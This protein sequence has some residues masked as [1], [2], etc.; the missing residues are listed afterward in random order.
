MSNITFNNYFSQTITT[1]SVCT[2]IVISGDVEF[3]ADGSEELILDIK[4]PCNY[5]SNNDKSQFYSCNDTINNSILEKAYCY[6]NPFID[7]VNL[8]FEINSDKVL[9]VE[10]LDILGK[11]FFKNTENFDSGSH[12]LSFSTHEL[13]PATYIIRIFNADSLKTFKIVKQ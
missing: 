10:I 13:P 3:I 8:Y 5:E 2:E 6:P 9:N 1:I 12:L 11:V 7:N 4:T